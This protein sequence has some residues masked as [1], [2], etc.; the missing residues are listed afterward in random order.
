[1]IASSIYY[2]KINIWTICYNIFIRDFGGNNMSERPH[3]RKRHDS[4]KE[5][6][7]HKRDQGLGSGPLNNSTGNQQQN[8]QRPGISRNVPRGGGALSI[9]ALAAFLLF[10]NGLSG[11]N[12]APS[13]TQTQQQTPAVTQ[14]TTPSNSSGYHF[15]TATTNN[16][17]YTNATTP[18]VNTTV[19]SGARDKYTK[20]LGNGKDQ[21]TVMVY[22]CGTDLESNYGM[23]TAD[24]NEMAY[25]A[26]SDN[27]NIIVE[28]GGTKRWKNSV[29][30]S[31]SNQIWRVSDRSLQKLEGNIGR[32][33]MTDAGT[34]AEF[35]QYCSKNFP[36]NRYILIMWDHGGGSYAGYGYDEVFPNGSMTVDKIAA[37][38][39]AGGVKFDIIG[40]DACLMAN[41][42]TAIAVEPYADYLLASEETEPG[43]GW[44]HV[45]WLS[46]LAQNS[47]V[48]SLDLGKTV[49][50]GFCTTKQ[51]NYA[52]SADK[53]TLSIVDLAEF[54][55]VVPDKL[56]NF[57]KMLTKQVQSNNY[58]TVADARSATR[59]FAS[60]QRID[61]IDLVHFCNTLNTPEAKELASAIQ[62]CVKYNRTRNINNAF[63][64]SIYFPYRNIR[65]VSSMV[66]IYDNIGFNSEYAGAVKS[67]AT[68]QSSGQAANNYTSSSLFDL[69]GGGSVS[70]GTPF[71]ALD[72]SSFLGGG[73]SSNVIDISSLLGGGGG[74]DTATYDLIS[75]LLGARS[76][77]DSSD[78][79]LTEKNGTKVLTLSEE[80]WK[81]VQDVKLNVWVKDGDGY[82]NLGLDNI[83]EF[84]DDND[85]LMEYDG[86]WVA[87]NDQIVTYY[88]LDS[89]PA[90]DGTWTTRGYIPCLLNGQK[91][92]L[93]VEYSGE[94]EYGAIIGAEM[95]YD[96]LQ[97]DGKMIPY[98]NDQTALTDEE[99]VCL[100]ATDTID[101]VCEFYDMNGNFSDVYP[102]GSRITV[103]DGLE[104]TDITVKAD[105]ILF[106]YELQDIYDSAR[107]TPMLT[108]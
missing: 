102:I 61:Q 87:V 59:E 108:Y 75:T 80:D 42:E 57:S 55:S 83:F 60:S 79:V 5:A 82:L 2:F 17:T 25:A 94:E 28:T 44:Y 62:S 65:R 104:V 68:L 10:G 24:L 98:I 52:S 54:K 49:I 105:Q 23:G 47:S 29:V 100:K 19:S 107:R 51:S 91:A 85:L 4:G 7:V 86:L 92:H 90:E 99:T 22:M 103:G 84:N 31:S 3:G 46:Q 48:S 41:M 101:F 88:M 21:V 106:G 26:H 45:D 97:T 14:Q 76:H 1:M 71:D 15:G 53:Y 70:N 78:L 64:I 8:R 72:L 11:G 33:S 12:A 89:E 56:T 27:V 67:F 34:L 35:I 9:L 6:E 36:A 69:L 30:S 81:L 18:Q 39:K 93:I 43:T 58:Q 66:Q 73:Q 13:N 63:G 96:D 50:D 95:V 74:V 20:L 16:V 38:L 40:F 77:L 37:G 32:K